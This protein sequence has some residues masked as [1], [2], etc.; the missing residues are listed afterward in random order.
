MFSRR[1]ALAGA[2]ASVVAACEPAFAAPTPITWTSVT[3]EG[4]PYMQATITGNSY[5]IACP[6]QDFPDQRAEMEAMLRDRL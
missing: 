5:W 3:W 4:R 6:V 2:L 1:H